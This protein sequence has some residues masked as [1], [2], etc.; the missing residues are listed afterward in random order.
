MLQEVTMKVGSFRAA[1]AALAAFAVLA[2]G[3][4]LA[5]EAPR[6]PCAESD[7]PCLKRALQ[8]HASHRLQ[9]WTADLARPLQERISP[10]PPRLVEFL[11]LDNILNGWSERPRAAT[12]DAAFM[13]DM[14]SAMAELPS[15][16]Q[17]LFG[18]RLAGIYLVEDLGGTGYTDFVVDENG[19]AA[20]GLIVLDAAVL[21]GRNANAWASWKENTPFQPQAG[22]QLAARIEADG[23]DNRKNAIQYILLHELGHVLS[24]GGDIHPPW[25]LEPKEVPAS[26]RYRFFDL[27][28]KVDRESDSY[29]TVFDARFPQRKSVAYYFGAKLTA[30]DMVSTYTNLE[31]TSFASLYA[32]TSPGDDFAEAFASYVHVV[33]L[34]RPWQ[35]TITRAGEIVKT[36]NA[37]WDEPRCADKRRVLEDIL[38]QPQ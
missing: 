28:W 26:A 5:Q 15:S 11:H 16:I 36:F 27:S 2:G 9:G 14:R 22:L 6:L 21:A 20:A 33:L 1:I 10:A 25:N 7:K 38:A 4:A 19:K 35:I 18:R 3:P 32:S 12:P 13:K 17:A 30:A 31:Q 24:I 37:C 34:R 8:D 23:Q 29:V